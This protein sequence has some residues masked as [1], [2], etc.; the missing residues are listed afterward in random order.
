VTH[1]RF[2]YLPGLSKPRAGSVTTGI[3]CDQCETEMVVRQATAENPYVYALS[4]LKNVV[5]V[6]IP[7]RSCP[8]CRIEV[9]TIPRVG[10]LHRVMADNLI[11]QDAP[12]TGDRLRFLRKN[13]GFAARKF[14]ALLGIDPSH[15]SRVETKGAKLGLPTER[16]ARAVVMA[17]IRGG[18]E[19]RRVLLDLAKKNQK[20]RA[21]ERKTRKRAGHSKQPLQFSLRGNRWAA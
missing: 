18:E 17:E 16:L 9:P 7:V 20:E 8:K 13:A 6:G 21:E 19:A 11:K 14:A 1:S 5:L 15:L 3:T 10:E 4:G 2:D 12:L